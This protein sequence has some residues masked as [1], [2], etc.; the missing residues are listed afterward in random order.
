MLAQL[1]RAFRFHVLERRS[2]AILPHSGRAA[3]SSLIRAAE[4]FARTD[5]LRRKE[6]MATGGI[7]K[8]A[9]RKAIHIDL[10]ELEILSS[11]HS[12]DEEIAGWLGVS[13]RTIQNRR[14]QKKFAE[15]MRRGRARGCVNVRRAQM[16]LLDAGNPTMAV[17]LG[18]VLLGQRDSMQITGAN[19]GPIQTESKSDYSQLSVDELRILQTTL[20][21]VIDKSAL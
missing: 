8:G 2:R 15:V 4:K 19:G 12:S 17:W 10:K 3:F 20:A 13:L 16:K 7:R 11:L 18:K 5:A 9:G 21:K 1:A 6:S 14:K